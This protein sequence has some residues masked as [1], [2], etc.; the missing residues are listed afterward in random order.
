M[1]GEENYIRLYP[2][3]GFRLTLK[4]YEFRWNV[5]YGWRLGRVR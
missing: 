2:N 5:F 4:G 1:I 3:P